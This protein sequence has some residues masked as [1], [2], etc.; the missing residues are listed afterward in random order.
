VFVDAGTVEES[1][2]IVG[3]DFR[4][5]PG[6]GLRIKVPGMGAA[7]IALDFAWAVNKESTDETQVFSFFVG[8]F[9]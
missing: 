1:V 9:R 2:K 5:A 3:S 8:F 7:P 6:A 4:V